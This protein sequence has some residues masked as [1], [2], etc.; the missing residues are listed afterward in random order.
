MMTMATIE[1]FPIG[2]PQTLLNDYQLASGVNRREQAG[3]VLAASFRPR[4]G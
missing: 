4:K 1:T 3:S 2:Y